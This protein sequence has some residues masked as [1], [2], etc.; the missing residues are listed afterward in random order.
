MK[1]HE[2]ET[3]IN[4]NKMRIEETYDPNGRKPRD[5]RTMERT[6]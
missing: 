1:I 5:K 4:R 6:K 3:L 2:N